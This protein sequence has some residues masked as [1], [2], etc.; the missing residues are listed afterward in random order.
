ML[1][2][3]DITNKLTPSQF[4]VSAFGAACLLGALLLKLPQA[5]DG[6]ISFIDALF[7]STSAVCVTG[8]IVV[9]T[10]TKFT[11]FGQAVIL[12][13]IQAGGLGITTLGV[14]FTSVLSGRI[15]LKDRSVIRE[16][17]AHYGIV[18]FRQLLLE[19][20]VFTITV[21]MIGAALLFFAFDGGS[22]F[23]AVF[24]SIAAFCN[25]GFSLYPDSLVGYR[26]NLVVNIV[27]CFLIITGG[28]GFLVARDVRL[29]LMRKAGRLTL[30]TKIVLTMT[31]ILLAAGCVLILGIEWDNALGGL[32]V[33]DKILVSFFQS[34]TTRTAGFNTIDLTLFSGSTLFIM[35]LLMFIGASPGSCGGGIKTSTLAVLLSFVRNRARGRE[36][37]S[38]FKRTIPQEVISKTVTL[39]TASIILVFAS[40]LVVSVS[41]GWGSSHMKSPGIFAETLFEVVSAFG[42]VGL[43]LGLTDELSHFGKMVIIL[44]MLSGRV[45]PLAIA[46][47]IG[48]EKPVRF[49]YV[50]EKVMVG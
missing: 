10:G 22:V 25:A 13:L 46:I 48:G 3:S 34:V 39:V 7:T 12:G 36:E 24:H 11:T 31:L 20:I 33:K 6:G 50:E 9:D 43:S 40:V 32:D 37:A 23:N 30:H 45:G 27:I 16:S 29:Y 8:L 15:S 1:K 35:I 26:G 5:T 21:E 38:L 41:E 49:K 19:I 2:P 47:A 44:T 4:I 18:N 17:F 28:I 14:L 42:T